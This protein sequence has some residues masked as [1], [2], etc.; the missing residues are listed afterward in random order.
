MQ[1]HLVHNGIMLKLFISIL[2]LLYSFVSFSCE[3]VIF[4]DLDWDSSRFH[5][6]VASFIAKHGYECE[7]DRIPGTTTPMLTALGSGD[8][9]VLMEIWKQNVKDAWAKLENDNKVQDLG[10]NFPDGIQGWFVPRYLVEGD[11]NRK[12]AP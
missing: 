3:K 11:S 6:G 5:V 8:V 4:G 9:H 12:I 10:L 2:L 7:T 1:C